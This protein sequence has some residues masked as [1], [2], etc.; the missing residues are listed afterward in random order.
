MTYNITIIRTADT[1]DGDASLYPDLSDEG[2]EYLTALEPEDGTAIIRLRPQSLTIHELQN[3]KLVSLGRLN[4][5]PI[6]V[7]ITDTRVIVASDKFTKGGG[8]HG[9]SVSGLAVAAAANAV[10]RAR[11][12]RKRKGKVFVG[13]VRYPWLVKVG[14]TKRTGMGTSNGIRLA[15]V[16]NTTGVKRRL[17]LSLE[18]DKRTDAPALAAEIARR[19]AR[20][21]LDRDITPDA[22]NRG[23]FEALAQAVPL[24]PEPKSYAFHS[25]GD[26]FFVKETTAYL[27][28]S[29]TTG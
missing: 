10:S 12:A 1:D 25:T 19:C 22:K 18:L 4:D 29:E 15:V 11:A 24:T 16:D 13:H 5:V 9:F 26:Y 14:A 21:R 3:D 20:F 23:K 8:W 17:F 28:R 27:K 2:S 7:Y 6:D